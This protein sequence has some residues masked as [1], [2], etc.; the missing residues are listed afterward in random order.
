MRLIT[1]SIFRISPPQCYLQSRQ[2][3]QNKG[4]NHENQ[5]VGPESAFIP[6]NVMSKF[7]VHM[8]RGNGLH[9]TQLYS[10]A[11]TMMQ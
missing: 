6:W 9:P 8:D 11:T 3:N 10:D 7:P 4:N 5:P 2:Y 1:K